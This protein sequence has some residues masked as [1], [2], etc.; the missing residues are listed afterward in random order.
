MQ[1][2]DATSRTVLLELKAIGVVTSI[3]L[4]RIRA[5]LAFHTRQGNHHSYRSLG[6]FSPKGGEED[7]NRL[8]P[9]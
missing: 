3:L 7:K 9:P 2:M 6:H 1:S 5:F 8:S 4:C